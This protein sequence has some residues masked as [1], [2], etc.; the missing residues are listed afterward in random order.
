MGDG[1]MQT[2]MSTCACECVSQQLLGTGGMAVISMWLPGAVALGLCT[3]LRAS[4]RHDAAHGL[5]MYACRCVSE[6]HSLIQLPRLLAP[7]VPHQPFSHPHC[8]LGSIEA[9]VYRQQNGL[10]SSLNVCVCVCVCARVCA[11]MCLQ[12]TPPAVQPHNIHFHAI[13]HSTYTCFSNV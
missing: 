12:G 10:C 8:R 13:V 11:R 1:L 5:Y 9:C 4:V 6:S 2:C 7:K 3:T